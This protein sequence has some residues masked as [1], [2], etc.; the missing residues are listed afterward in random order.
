MHCRTSAHTGQPVNEA[1]TSHEQN[2]YT[3]TIRIAWRWWLIAADRVGVPDFL[4]IRL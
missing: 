4:L 1:G 2:V 3:I